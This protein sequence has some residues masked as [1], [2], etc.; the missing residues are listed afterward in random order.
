M[1]SFL[2]FEIGLNV[3]QGKCTKMVRSSTTCME[4]V[5]PSGVNASPLYRSCVWSTHR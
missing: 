2:V 1:S 5:A 4:D 3:Y